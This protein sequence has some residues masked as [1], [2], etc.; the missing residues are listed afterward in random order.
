MKTSEDTI[1]ETRRT[2][3]ETC[4]TSSQWDAKKTRWQTLPQKVPK[5]TNTT[6]KILKGSASTAGASASRTKEVD[7]KINPFKINKN[8]LRKKTTTVKAVTTGRRDITTKSSSTTSLRQQTP[9]NNNEITN[10]D[11]NN[12]NTSNKYDDSQ[13]AA[14]VEAPIS[15]RVNQ[16]DC[17]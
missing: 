10:E 4:L 3:P 5:S 6:K 17:V 8:H 13:V 12:E 1:K 15:D 14:D 11:T 7:I 2:E 16:D 9:E